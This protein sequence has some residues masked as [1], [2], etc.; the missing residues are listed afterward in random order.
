MINCKADSRDL[1]RSLLSL[2][3]NVDFVL[4]NEISIF[5]LCLKNDKKGLEREN[6]NNVS[7]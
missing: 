5:Q 6:G 7:L 3:S 2:Q 1:T 4:V